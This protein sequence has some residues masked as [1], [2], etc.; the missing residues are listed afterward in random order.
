M[1]ILILGGY[2][3]TGKLVARHLLQQTQNH[4]IIAGRHLDKAQALVREFA[5]E[6]IAACQLDAANRSA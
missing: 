5:D 2:G 6:R 4:I 3:S 1:N